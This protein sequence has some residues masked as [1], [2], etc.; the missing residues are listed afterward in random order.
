[1]FTALNIL[2]GGVVHG[3]P[4]YQNLIQQNTVHI[5][6]VVNQDGLA[7]IEKNFAKT[8]KVLKKR[9]N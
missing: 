9:K 6:P 7:L 8:G 2:H 5:V 1:M 4:Y 3:D